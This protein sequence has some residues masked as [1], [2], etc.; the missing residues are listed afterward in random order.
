MKIRIEYKTEN[1]LLCRVLY[2]EVDDNT[3]VE[4][5]RRDVHDTILDDLGVSKYKWKVVENEK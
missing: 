3:Q 1:S 5:I 4:D 2:I